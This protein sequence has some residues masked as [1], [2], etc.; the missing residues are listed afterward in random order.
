MRDRN[1]D[2]FVCPQNAQLLRKETSPPGAS[3]DTYM[4]HTPTLD[5][6]LSL[7]ST[8]CINLLPGEM[9]CSPRELR[10]AP[11]WCHSRTGA[12][13]TWRRSKRP[14]RLLPRGEWRN[15]EMQHFKKRGWED[16]EAT[17]SRVVLPKDHPRS[18]KVSGKHTG[19]C[20]D[21]IIELRVKI[22]FKTRAC[23]WVNI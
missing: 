15:L 7:E 22:A 1:H 9:M 19:M 10:T 23:G 13:R 12:W 8:V 6:V 14:C 3:W 2:G 5:C 4:T 16:E 18:S 20:L 17:S 21:G 11:A